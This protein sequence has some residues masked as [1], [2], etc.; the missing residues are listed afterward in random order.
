MRLLI[1]RRTTDGRGTMQILE[2]P[3]P[4]VLA[5]FLGRQA[6]RCSAVEGVSPKSGR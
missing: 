1:K 5:K 6:D 2:I 3:K 4:T